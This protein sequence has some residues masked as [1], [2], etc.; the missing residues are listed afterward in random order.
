ML[1]VSEVYASV[2]GEGPDVGRTTVFVR[3]AGCN[4]RCSGWPCDTQHAIDPAYRKEWQ[5]MSV[6]EL[7][8]KI[9]DIMDISGANSITLTGGEPFLQNNDELYELIN[10]FPM[11]IINCFSN[12]TLPYPKWAPE[13]MTFIMDWKL[14]GSGENSVNIDTRIANIKLLD[15]ANLLHSVKFV[16]S[17][18]SDF[19]EAVSIYFHYLEKFTNIEVFYG[20]VWDSYITDR[21]LAEAVMMNQL[22]W[23][24]NIQLH[25]YIWPANERGK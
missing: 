19:E 16:I 12:G 1:R 17:D 3:F 14:L 22:P 8:N 5:S 21:D 6:E 2:Q 20:R 25:N 9:S 23:R 7:A 18:W 24:L 11:T 13:L 15:N 10:K 4:L